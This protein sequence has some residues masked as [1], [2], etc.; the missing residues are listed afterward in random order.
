[1]HDACH[2]QVS[3]RNQFSFFVCDFEWQKEYVKL[4]LATH[5][6]QGFIKG[7]VVGH[8]CDGVTVERFI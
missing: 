4:L 7:V 8:A 3:I 1:M 6:C 2:A 5:G